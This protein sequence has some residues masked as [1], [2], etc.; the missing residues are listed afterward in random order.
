MVPFVLV[1]THLHGPVKSG[2]LDN[3]AGHMSLVSFVIC[4]PLSENPA[5]LHNSVF[6]INAIEIHWVKNVYYKNNFMYVLIASVNSD[7]KLELK[8]LIHQRIRLFM[9][10]TKYLCF[11]F[12]PRR[13]REL[14]VFVSVAVK[15]NFVVAVSKLEQPSCLKA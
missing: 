13:K 5:I 7:G 10:R 8:S 9:E 14:C 15:C 11:V 4:D 2:H 3:H 6:E 1:Y 12:V